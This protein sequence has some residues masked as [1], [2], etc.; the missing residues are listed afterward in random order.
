AR[1]TS[2]K[3][4]AAVAVKKVPFEVWQAHEL[5]GMVALHAKDYDTALKELAQ[6]SNQKPRGN[7]PTRPAHQGQGGS[8]QAARRSRA[9]DDWNQLKGLL[10]SARNAARRQLTW[11]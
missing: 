3:Y 2:E 1:A 8:P 7:Y 11:G 4:T 10:P 6:A 9:A 5:A